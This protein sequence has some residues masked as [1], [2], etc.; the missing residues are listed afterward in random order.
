MECRYQFCMRILRCFKTRLIVGCIFLC[1]ILWNYHEQSF[2]HIKLTDRD[3][4]VCD[5]TMPR[6]DR[7]RLEY[8]FRKMI[9]QDDFGY[10]LLGQK[11]LSLASYMDPFSSKKTLIFFDAILPK[12]L[13]L[14]R[15]WQTWE[16]YQ[17][18]FCNPSF[19]LWREKSPWI[20]C[21]HVI[22]LINKPSAKLLL[23][24]QQ[25]DFQEVLQK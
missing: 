16:K 3:G 12:N 23:D 25:A 18:L 1:F 9:L 22:L 13:R 2:V 11:P 24:K 20:D 21:A 15:G 7:D 8:L 17:H 5:L 10:T 14:K 4:H 6:R 19:A